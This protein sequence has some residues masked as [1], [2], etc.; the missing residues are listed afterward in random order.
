M[1]SAR[2]RV[3]SITWDTD[4]PRSVSACI[5]RQTVLHGTARGW[6]YTFVQHL[7]VAWEWTTVAAAM[8]ALPRSTLPL[9]AL[10]TV[11]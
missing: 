6:M 4:T 11:S 3:C 7:Q 10:M 2:C 9:T 1:P 5:G 8:S